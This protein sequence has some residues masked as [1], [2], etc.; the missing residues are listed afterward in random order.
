MY[1]RVTRQTVK[2]QARK[3]LAHLPVKPIFYRAAR[4][5]EALGISRT[6]LWRLWKRGVLPPPTKISRGI[7]GWPASTVKAL[8]GST[9]PAED[10]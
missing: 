2:E 4:L 5:A 1:G 9:R 7:S 3:V 6:T 10:D 8:L